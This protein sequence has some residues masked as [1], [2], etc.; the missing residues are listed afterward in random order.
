MQQ[1]RHLYILISRA[2]SKFLPVMSAYPEITGH[3]RP[4]V[5]P[6][7]RES[8]I[9][10]V[11]RNGQTAISA[12]ISEKKLK[13]S[14]WQEMGHPKKAVIS[15]V[16]S[17]LTSEFLLW[18]RSFFSY[19]RS[20]LQ[21]WYRFWFFAVMSVLMF[22]CC[23]FRCSSKSSHW[24]CWRGQWLQLLINGCWWSERFWR[25]ISSRLAKFNGQCRAIRPIS[26][27]HVRLDWYISRSFQ[28]GIFSTPTSI[29]RPAATLLFNSRGHAG[30]HFN[31]LIQC[32]TPY[33]H[34]VYDI[35]PDI[36]R[37]R[38]HSDH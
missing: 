37:Q 16:I 35:I 11:T 13:Y 8:P 31:I 15:G 14:E 38:W 30:K 9:S 24:S 22:S 27:K 5:R 2:M 23:L 7:I 18:Y 19:I 34:I 29:G 17:G 21:L 33:V 4:D 28:Q 3:I 10:R 26:R 6:D 25:P 20:R 36:N 1:C 32:Y 12:V